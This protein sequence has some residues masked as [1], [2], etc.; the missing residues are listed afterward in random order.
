MSEWVIHD[1]MDDQPIGLTAYWM[2]K[3]I[4]RWI[5]K[6]TNKQT[7]QKPKQR[8]HKNKNNKTQKVWYPQ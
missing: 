6:Q 1:L 2:K 4:D 5:N 3:W 8:K 7:P